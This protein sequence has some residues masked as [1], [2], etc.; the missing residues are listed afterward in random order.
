MHENKR[1]PCKVSPLLLIIACVVL[2][3]F[4]RFFPLKAQEYALEGMRF[5]PRDLQAKSTSHKWLEVNSTDRTL[6][7][8]KPYLYKKIGR[9]HYLLS[10]DSPNVKME[11]RMVLEKGNRYV[12]VIEPIRGKQ[13]PIVISKVNGAVLEGTNVPVRMGLDAQ[14][15]FYFD[16]ILQSVTFVKSQKLD[17]DVPIAYE[18]DSKATISWIKEERLIKERVV[19]NVKE[20]HFDEYG[21]FYNDKNCF[22]LGTEVG[23][24]FKETD[25]GA[26]RLFY[27]VKDQQGIV[28]PYYFAVDQKSDFKVEQQMGV[29]SVQDVGKIV[30]IDGQIRIHHR[31]GLVDISRRPDSL[32][33]FRTKNQWAALSKVAGSDSLWKIKANEDSSLE[34][35]MDINAK[36]GE[37]R[38]KPLYL[39]PGFKGKI[40]LAEG[41]SAIIFGKA[42]NA[43]R[44]QTLVIS[45]EGTEVI[46]DPYKISFRFLA[47]CGV[48]IILAAGLTVVLVRQR[49]QGFLANR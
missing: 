27:L 4:S 39:A 47:I 33:H 21:S 17:K 26:E 48:V 37:S 35:F 42:Y 29:S 28:M 44:G 36:T 6:I 5:I 13:P 41:E 14:G 46:P 43:N 22:D 8:G 45:W 34:I 7:K 49:R 2:L 1:F 9:R 24:L 20:L 19:K 25:E 3:S 12:S 10:V 23:P 32:Q 11:V 16:F 30:A 18:N 15:N 31:E 40:H 38:E